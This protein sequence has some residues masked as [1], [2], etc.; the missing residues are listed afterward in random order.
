MPGF[1]GFVAESATKVAAGAVGARFLGESATETAAILGAE[2]VI[3]LALGDAV[4]GLCDESVLF[5]SLG[6]RIACLSTGTYPIAVLMQ[7]LVIP[8]LAHSVMS[9]LF[10]HG[11]GIPE[12]G[13]Q[14]RELSYEQYL[15]ITTLAKTS[16]WLFMW[17]KLRN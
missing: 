15:K 8:D 6:G 16:F 10:D 9:S 3:S 12:G 14:H 11:I 5:G 2:Q 1:V 4:S 7:G 13:W 17:L